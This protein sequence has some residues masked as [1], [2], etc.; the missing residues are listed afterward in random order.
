MGIIEERVKG[1]LET[2][3]KRKTGELPSPDLSVRCL[4]CGTLLVDGG[5]IMDDGNL[6]CLKCGRDHRKTLF[7]S[8]DISGEFIRRGKA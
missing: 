6:F 3:E 2:W 5:F 1:F 7:D 8:Q 4:A